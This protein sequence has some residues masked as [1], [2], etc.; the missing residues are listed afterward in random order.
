MS[1]VNIALNAP[2]S[3][4]MVLGC[5]PCSILDTRSSVS[6]VVL[7]LCTHGSSI[8]SLKRSNL[9]RVLCPDFISWPWY[10]HHKSIST[11]SGRRSMEFPFHSLLC[12]C[13]STHRSYKTASDFVLN[14]LRMRL[15]LR[16]S[17]RMSRRYP[18]GI[19][20]MLIREAPALQD[21]HA[22]SVP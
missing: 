20:F 9:R 10:F 15:P 21:H 1:A 6:I 11:D 16:P 18:P 14:F 7:S 17:G 22:P 12:C 2:I 8:A 5:I 4:F 13:A 3:R 19:D